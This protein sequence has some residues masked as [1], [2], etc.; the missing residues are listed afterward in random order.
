MLDLDS[1]QEYDLL[2]TLYLE[3]N[4]ELVFWRERNWSTM[5]WVIGAYVAL[6]GLTVFRTATGAL[7]LLVA[8]LAVI[9][10]VYLLK[11]FK[12][13]QERREIGAKIEKALRLYEQD[14][15]LRGDI[16][17][18]KKLETAKAAKAGSWAFIAAIWAVAI[19]AGVAILLA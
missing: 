7:S 19:A 14:V 16:L 3:N 15:F 4:K 8:A 1:A 6:A 9:A 18:L 13:Y 12:R 2:K 5:K 17:L 10:T 11:N